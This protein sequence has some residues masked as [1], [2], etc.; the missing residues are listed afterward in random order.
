MRIFNNRYWRILWRTRKNDMEVAADDAWHALCHNI[1]FNS[2]DKAS[3]FYLQSN[4]WRSDGLVLILFSTLALVFLF[5][6][7]NA[8][9]PKWKVSFFV[10][11]FINVSWFRHE[12]GD[13]NLFPV[14]NLKYMFWTYK[15]LCYILM[16]CLLCKQ[17]VAS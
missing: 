12:M 13:Q 17:Y 10:V 3:V 11:T 15:N 2:L 4:T 14:T 1:N 6:S 9:N 7:M 8:L 5:H 16:S